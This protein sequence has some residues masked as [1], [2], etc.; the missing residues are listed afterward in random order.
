M[1]HADVIIIGSGIAALQLA[2]KL[3]KNINVMILTKKDLR[4]GNSYMAQG[5]VAA[6]MA[7]GD[8]FYLHYLDTLEAGAHHNNAEAVL[9]MTKSA[10]KLIKDLWEG[11]CTFDEDSNGSLLLGMEGAHSRNRI[12]HSGGDATGKHM[13]DHLL[14]KFD[15][16]ISVK[17]S[18]FV[19]ELLLNK[20]KNTCIGVKAKHP[21]GRNDVYLAPHIVVA[22]GG[23]GQLY[24]FTSNAETATGDGMALAYRAGAMLADMEF[25]QFHPTL[26]YLEGKTRGLISEAVRGEGAILVTAEGKRIMD[27]VHPLKDLAPRHIVSQTIYDYLRKGTQIYLDIT[28]VSDFSSR[29]PTISELCRKHGIDLKEGL[30]PVVPGSHFIM[31]GIKTD[32]HG[33]TNINGLYAIGEAACTGIHGANRLA[34]NSLLE[35]MFVGGKLADWINQQLGGKVDT[36]YTAQNAKVFHDMELPDADVLKKAMMDRA[37]I[38]RTR[39]ALVHQKD[40][41]AKYGLEE[42]L[43]ASLDHL[44]TDEIDRVFMYITAWLITEA[45]FQRTESRGGH[46][47]EDFPHEDPYNW[48]KRQIIHQRK[49]VKDGKHEY[50]Q[51]AFA[52]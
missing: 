24:S 27:G 22:T 40:W 35:G 39:E 32:L 12:I 52:T 47:R 44:G 45:A 5:G 49:T 33:R 20:E 42:W 8:D 31:G 3:A 17:P 26:L 9:E 23:C 2:N 51:I 36:Y 18:V 41:L 11:G 14:S 28:P 4:T 19:Y 37:G 38:V 50:N 15:G 10:P 46:Y 48:M 43:E 6:A 21:D 34:S 29:F 16:N 7:P 30:I 1:K 13:V 25:V